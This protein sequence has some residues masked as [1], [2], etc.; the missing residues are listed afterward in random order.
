[1]VG[2][3]IVP[4]E[5]RP[6]EADVAQYERYGSIS[7]FLRRYLFEVNEVSRYPETPMEQD[8][9]AFAESLFPS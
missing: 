1:M 3:A 7:A 8:A 4:R 6:H 2:Q 5:P 9:V